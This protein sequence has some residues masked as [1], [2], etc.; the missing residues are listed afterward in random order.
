MWGAYPTAT[1]RDDDE[2]ERRVV[3]LAEDFPLLTSMTIAMRAIDCIAWLIG[4]AV[5]RV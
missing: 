4:R 2:T 3:F 5:P 1:S